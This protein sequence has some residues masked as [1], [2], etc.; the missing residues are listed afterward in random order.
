MDC[1]FDLN[2]ISPEANKALL[3]RKRDYDEYQ[4]QQ[5]ET[6]RKKRDLDASDKE[7]KHI[8][9]EL[10]KKLQLELHLTS[11]IIEPLTQKKATLAAES[12]TLEKEVAKKKEDDAR[13]EEELAK[14][15]EEKE[16]TVTSKARLE[17]ELAKKKEDDA[18][19]EEEL[20]KKEEEKEQTVTSKARL[21]KELAKKNE[22]KAQIEEELA[23]K[24]IEK[25][26]IQE[27]IQN[28]TKIHVVPIASN[29]KSY[30]L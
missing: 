8:M 9:A 27:Q 3:K 13:L 12:A 7:W 22:E 14:K 30:T 16:Q 2:A 18:R 28:V 5:K 19:L 20:S 15:K 10:C 24:K 1:D 11:S 4:I 26:Q 23:K 21:E 25:A 17:K 29:G 6:S